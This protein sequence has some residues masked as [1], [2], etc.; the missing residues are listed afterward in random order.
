MTSSN[1][2]RQILIGCVNDNIIAN[3]ISN[4][5]NYGTR[6]DRSSR[7]ISIISIITA[8]NSFVSTFFVYCNIG[9]FSETISAII[10][11]YI[12]FYILAIVAFLT[13]NTLGKFS[14]GLLIIIRRRS[15]SIEALATLGKGNVA[16]LHSSRR[17]R[18]AFSNG[19]AA[20]KVRVTGH[21]PQ[22]V[23]QG[24][25]H[26]TDI[27]FI[28]R[29]IT[30]S[31][32]FSNAVVAGVKHHLGAGLGIKNLHIA[33][34][35]SARRSISMLIPNLGNAFGIGNLNRII[36]VYSD[37]AGRCTVFAANKTAQMGHAIIVAVA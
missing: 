17:S 4:G 22:L 9:I 31:Q 30:F 20:F 2:K 16:S 26:F 25:Q 13:E 3:C 11:Q 32:A 24:V 27:V 34:D 33:T 29:S 21:I 35:N 37:D 1:T 8:I 28:Y 15:I 23:R 18:Q 6:S 12:T 14:D 5:S 36:V 7:N 19:Y 10:L